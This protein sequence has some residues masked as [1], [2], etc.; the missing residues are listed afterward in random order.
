MDITAL[1]LFSGGVPPS[2]PLQCFTCYRIHSCSLV[3]L[4]LL[5]PPFVFNCVVYKL[6]MFFV[7][8]TIP[9]PMPYERVYGYSEY[10]VSI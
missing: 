5:L 8:K 2:V 9:I 3:V 1:I 4:L 10:K 6:Q 7:D